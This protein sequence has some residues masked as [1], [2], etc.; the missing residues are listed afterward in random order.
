MK[1]CWRPT[2]RS[3][4]SLKRSKADPGEVSL[5][6]KLPRKPFAEK[7]LGRCRGLFQLLYLLNL[8]NSYSNFASSFFNSCLPNIGNTGVNILLRKENGKQAAGKRR[9]NLSLRAFVKRRGNLASNFSYGSERSLYRRGDSRIARLC[10]YSCSCKGRRT[11]INGRFVKRPYDKREMPLQS[12]EPSYPDLSP[13][14]SR[15]A[16]KAQLCFVSPCFGGRS[17]KEHGV[18]FFARSNGNICIR[19]RARACELFFRPAGVSRGGLPSGRLR[20]IRWRYRRKPSFPPN[21]FPC[22]YP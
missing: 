21:G 15:N 6:A 19:K 5:A 17:K 3:L 22:C 1:G 7:A 14:H 16:R 13:L 8:F 12:I 10:K 4:E 2:K 9:R 20:R 18:L 11:A